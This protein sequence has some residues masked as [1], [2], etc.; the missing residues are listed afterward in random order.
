MCE[1][2]D[3]GIIKRIEKGILVFLNDERTI[4][5]LKSYQKD[6]CC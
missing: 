6:Q 3:T 2:R 4:G 1:E 5:D